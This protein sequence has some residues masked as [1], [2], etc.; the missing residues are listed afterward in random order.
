MLLPLLSLVGA[1]SFDIRAYAGLPVSVLEA[2]WGKAEEIEEQDRYW[3][4][5]LERAP[6]FRD[7]ILPGGAPTQSWD[8]DVTLSWERTEG[9]SRD[10][11]T[12]AMVGTKFG[13]IYFV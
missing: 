13:R 2:R 12:Q 9:L 8:R 4:G 6:R 3:R 11:L 7:V 10:G 1:A 5:P